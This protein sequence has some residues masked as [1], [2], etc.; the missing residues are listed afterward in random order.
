MLLSV[1][2]HVYPVNAAQSISKLPILASSRSSLSKN[3]QIRPNSS[4]FSVLANAGIQYFQ[5]FTKPCGLIPTHQF[6]FSDR[7]TGGEPRE[8]NNLRKFLPF[9]SFIQR[10]LGRV[11]RGLPR[12]S[13]CSS[14]FYLFSILLILLICLKLPQISPTLASSRTRGSSKNNNLRK[15]LPLSSFILH[16]SCSVL[17]NAGI[18]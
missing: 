4:Y 9:S 3:A 16:P 18:Q 7:L 2:N 14:C 5:L 17:A 10:P 15:F 8:N 1:F 13:C 12:V 11:A 6:S